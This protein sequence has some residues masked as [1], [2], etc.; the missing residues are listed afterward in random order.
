MR[1]LV[2]RTAHGLGSSRAAAL[3]GATATLTLALAFTADS[4]AQTLARPPETERRYLSG[5]DVDS[6]I[7]WQFR[8]DAGL[9]AGTW[10]EIPVPSH[11]EQH[12]FGHYAYGHAERLSDEV[13][14]YRTR[15]SVP[16]T[17]RGRRVRL[18]FEGA[19]T[20]TTPV[21]N[22]TKLATHQGGFTPFS[23][24]VTGLLRFGGDNELEVRVTERSANATIN[25]A[26]RGADYWV[27]GG[28]YRPVYLE[29]VPPASIENVALDARHDGTLTVTIATRS[30]PEG[31]RL[32]VRVLEEQGR[33]LQPH[34]PAA[35]DAPVVRGA[36]ARLQ[37][38]FAQ[39]LPWSAEAPNLYRL[40]TLLEDAR[41][42]P[43]H[44]V[45][46]RFGFRTIELRLGV[47]S[48][49]G[50]A[51]AQPGL[52][53][54]GQ[55]ILL[56]GVNRHSFWP[57]TGRAGSPRRNREDV[58]RLRDLHFNAVRTSHYPPDRA[59]LEACDEAGLYVL[60]ELP[61]W[62]DAYD[63]RVGAAILRAMLRRDRNHPS[64]IL[65]ANGNE[66]GWNRRL[67]R[68]FA[69][70]DPQR[71]PVLHPDA[72]FGGFDTGHY[73][74]YEELRARLAEPS[75]GRAGSLVM[76]TELL[77]GL[78]DGGGGAGLGVYWEALRRAPR[79]AGGF[80]WSFADE[81]IARSDRGG[82]LDHHGNSAPDGILGPWREETGSSAAVRDVLA[83]V[84][85]LAVERADAASRARS[86]MLTPADRMTGRRRLRLLVENRADP[87]ALEGVRLGWRR[88]RY[89]GPL[90][91]AAPR[92]LDGGFLFAPRVEP[93]DTAWL[94]LEPLAAVF[95]PPKDPRDPLALDALEV[96]VTRRDTESRAGVDHELGRW[97][98]P[99]DDSAPP[100]TSRQDAA[101]EER[102]V[103]S[104]DGSLELRGGG[105]IARFDATTGSLETIE[106]DGVPLPLRAERPSGRA[107]LRP[108]S[109]CAGPAA[110]LRLRRRSSSWSATRGLCA[111]RIGTST[112]LVGS[113]CATGS[114]TTAARRRLASRSP[115]FRG[116]R[117]SES[118]G[119][120]AAPT[121]CGATVSRVRRSGDGASIHAAPQRRCGSTRA[122]VRARASAGFVSSS[123][124][125]RGSWRLH[126]GAATMQP[127][128]CPTGT[129][130]C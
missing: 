17:W 12:G 49:T 71:R 72:D 18:C 15:F 87:L 89:G 23:Y 13:G 103:P 45:R 28:I 86:G 74:T 41:G 111:R 7:L 97:S 5:A 123:S 29:A 68:R 31:S 90:G 9:R 38:R 46:E 42:E 125:A 99:F 53:V 63:E 107:L 3:T 96:V 66:G 50:E 4:T 104:R 21:V 126:S 128:R 52:Y 102:A 116:R 101:G 112:K 106:R 124:S 35:L 67:D 58:E 73:P 60:D 1:S 19:M 59:F 62:H 43:L 118:S 30:A 98:L 48:E 14:S 92:V 33:E 47:P 69:A 119:W 27:F 117:S 65:W 24:D 113:A 56:R 85:L 78:Y 36:S 120:V 110:P 127:P 82:A 37:A 39:A 6:P 77:H 75:P 91:E 32:R 16:E 25:A 22:G 44:V 115:V 61:G 51:P 94:T 109:S 122:K 34:D 88:V 20:D 129:R 8:V 84:R 81:A 11:W 2:H 114:R 95:P 64:V 55:R 70:H 79:G 57:D 10:A 100:D 80:L 93:G 130:R 26:E 54:N 83:P 40:V 121:A 108:R 105:T 76:P